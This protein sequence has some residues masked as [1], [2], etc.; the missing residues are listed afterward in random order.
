MARA[1]GPGFTAFTAGFPGSRIDETAA[2]RSI[3]DH[4]GCKHVVLPIEPTV[5]WEHAK[6]FTKAVAELLEHT[7]PDRFTSKILKV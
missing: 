2:A 1:S 5:H 4:V 6:N 7:F 3:A